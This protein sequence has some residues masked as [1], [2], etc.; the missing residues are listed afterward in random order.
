MILSREAGDEFAQMAQ[1]ERLRVPAPRPRLTLQVTGRAER[2]QPVAVRWSASAAGAVELVLTGPDGVSRVVS[3]RLRGAMSFDDL[4]AGI[5]RIQLRAS[6]HRSLGP[7][8]RSAAASAETEIFVPAPTAWVRASHRIEAGEV[9]AISWATENA[10]QV[11]L[12]IG[13]EHQR[14]ARFGEVQHFAAQAGDLAIAITAHGDGGEV[15]ERTGI[16]VTLPALRIQAP[17]RVEAILG[18]LAV[19]EYS[20]RGAQPGTIRLAQP[21]RN[22]PALPLPPH[23]RIEVPELAESERF[24]LEATGIDGTRMTHAI[25]VIPVVSDISIDEELEFLHQQGRSSW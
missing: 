23:G 7:R 13:N 22:E 20:V 8:A 14:V 21:D 24:I 6:P 2:G 17:R 25:E 3:Q 5:H 12:T 11:W 4:E 18:E 15:V 10:N 19:I 16:V 9:L 1:G